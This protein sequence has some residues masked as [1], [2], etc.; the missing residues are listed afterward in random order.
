LHIEYTAGGAASKT[1]TETGASA[2]ASLLL[3][4]IVESDAAGGSDGIQ[5]RGVAL[6]DDGGG[7]DALTTL[8][9]V[10]LAG[11]AG[12]GIDASTLTS[13]VAKLS[14][15]AGSGIDTAGLLAMLASGE[16]GTGADTGVIPG[17]KNL[18]DGDGGIGGDTLKAL[19]GTSAAGSD[20][21]LPGHQSHVRI[22]SKGVSL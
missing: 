9:A 10:V 22:P 18:Y 14:A 8:F 3:A 4:D 13:L 7:T 21:K 12:S 15:E 6:K 1:A 11:E 17:Q 2:D 20:M 5:G 19:I 16:T